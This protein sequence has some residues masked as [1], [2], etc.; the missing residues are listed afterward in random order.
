MFIRF[1][2]REAMDAHQET[3]WMAKKYKICQIHKYGGTNKTHEQRETNKFNEHGGVN[4]MIGDALTI[5]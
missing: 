1:Y 2:R 5:E 3:L 4:K